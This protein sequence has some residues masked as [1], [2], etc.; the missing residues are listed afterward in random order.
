MN[1]N[2]YQLLDITVSKTIVH[3]P[4]PKLSGFQGLKSACKS[5]ISGQIFNLASVNG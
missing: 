1:F 3:F 4:L 5:S 2:L